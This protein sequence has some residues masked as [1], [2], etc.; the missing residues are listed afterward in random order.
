[1]TLS[2][3]A[4]SIARFSRDYDSYSF[5]DCFDT[6]EEGADQ[7][8]HM[9]QNDPNTVFDALA[10]M[11]SFASDAD[12]AEQATQLLAAVFSLAKSAA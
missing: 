7:I 5:D 11:L 10:S 12:E 2:N 6:L 4:Y 1:M 3:L 8:M 9:L